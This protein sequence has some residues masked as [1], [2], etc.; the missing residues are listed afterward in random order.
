MCGHSFSQLDDIVRNIL[1]PNLLRF[2]RM[3]DKKKNCR[4][5]LL[6]KSW[7]FSVKHVIYRYLRWMKSTSES[8]KIISIDHKL[9]E[10]MY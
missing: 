9:V 10:A 6:D 3:L 4:F 8:V 2:S 1:V 5:Y 7:Y